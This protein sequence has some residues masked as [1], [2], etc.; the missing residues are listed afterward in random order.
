MEGLLSSTYT[1]ATTVSQESVA[2]PD[3]KLSVSNY[4]DVLFETD[5]K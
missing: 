4:A 2:S 5:I 3:Q 1:K